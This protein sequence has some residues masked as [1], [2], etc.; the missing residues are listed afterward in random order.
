MWQSA[1]EEMYKTA[2]QTTTGQPGS[3]PG[4]DEQPG[5]G[6]TKPGNDEVTD[7]DFEEVK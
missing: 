1:S 5:G 6:K 3:Q 4:A 7:V 2:Q